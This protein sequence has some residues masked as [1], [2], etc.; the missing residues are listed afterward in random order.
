MAESKYYGIYQGVVSKTQDPE[1][2]GRIKVTCPTVLGD[3]TESAWCD[4][5]VP[6]AY[7]NGGDFCL[8]HS[9]ET[10]WV[11]FIEGDA[12]KPV[13]LGGWW[14]KEMTPLGGDYSKAEEMRVI[15]YAD[16]IITMEQGV[17][18]IT[19]AGGEFDLKIEDKKLTIEGELVIKN[20]LT[21]KGEIHRL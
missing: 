3:G 17:I 1:K 19:V 20:D 14:Q 2:R 18:N 21:V 4:P 5:V 12:N 9:G 8:P 11:Q 6:V 7:D 16:C 15:S 10:V 13:W